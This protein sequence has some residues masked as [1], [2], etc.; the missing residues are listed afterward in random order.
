[1][2]TFGGVSSHFAQLVWKATEEIGVGRAFGTKWGMNCSFIVVRYKPKSNNKVGVKENIE[3][4]TFDPVAYNCSAVECKEDA[5]RQATPSQDNYQQDKNVPYQKENQNKPQRFSDFDKQSLHGLSKFE[6]NHGSHG[7]S[8]TPGYYPKNQENVDRGHGVNS[9]YLSTDPNKDRPRA[10]I[11][12]A[13]L[14]KD[15]LI[16]IL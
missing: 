16:K 2:P 14:S 6:G 15:S 7:Y 1:M 5:Q 12:R 3:T 11:T 8:T 4:G 9:Q 13:H 10:F